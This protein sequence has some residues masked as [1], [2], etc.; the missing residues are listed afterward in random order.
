MAEKLVRDLTVPGDEYVF[1]SRESTL[2][3]AIIKLMQKKQ[4]MG[5]RGHTSIIV[6]D[7]DQKV[8]SLLTLFD[9]MRGLESQYQKV[10]QLDW[11]RFGFGED[12]LER[13]FS[14]HGLW[15]KPLE[16]LCSRVG[17]V[18]I[19]ELS[20][21]FESLDTIKAESTINGAI[22]KMIQ[23]RAHN[24]LVFDENE[25]FLGVLRT[26]DLFNFICSLVEK[27]ELRQ[28]QSGGE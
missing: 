19:S 4:E 17:M 18:R 22:S 7:S 8:V 21:E 3:D 20:R 24:L 25:E 13:L 16:D 23:N 9:I 5:D 6:T 1:L 28:G 2:M 27:C 14:D 26:V 11:N 15:L 10:D 12:K